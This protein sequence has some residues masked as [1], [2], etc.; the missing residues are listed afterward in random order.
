MN[1]PVKRAKN[2]SYVTNKCHRGN[3]YKLHA[4]YTILYFNNPDCIGCKIIGK[5]LMHSKLING[6]LQDGMISFLAV[7]TDKDKAAWR[8]SEQKYPELW[9]NSCNEDNR[10]EDVP[11]YDLKAMPTLY[12]LDKDKTVILKDCNVEDI[13]HYF[14]NK[15]MLS[16][17]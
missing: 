9:V 10:V 12:L 7:F 8:K 17:K 11:L 1:Q 13:E 15:N 2:F 16:C 5:K 6:L 14:I 3:L 4:N